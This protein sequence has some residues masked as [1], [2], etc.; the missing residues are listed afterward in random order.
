MPSNFY[1]A[2]FALTGEA[3]R[4]FEIMV[5]EDE[6]LEKTVSDCAAM[7]RGKMRQIYPDP[8]LC[9]QIFLARCVVIAANYG[10]R[11]GCGCHVAAAFAL[12]VCDRVERLVFE[13][14]REEQNAH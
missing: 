5:E 14:D 1:P 6:I 13:L 9:R 3:R 10:V 11:K 7:W 4:E 2:F 8:V 12:Y